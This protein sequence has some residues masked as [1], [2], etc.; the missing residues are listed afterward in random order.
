MRFSLRNLLICVTLLFLLLPAMR[1]IAEYI[2]REREKG[3]LFAEIERLKLK[4]EK[5]R[6][7]RIYNTNRPTSRIKLQEA[8]LRRLDEEIERLVG[9][10][11]EIHRLLEIVDKASHSPDP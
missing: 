3:I 10:D 8:E 1:P 7:A 2:R 4:L 11:G 5:E 9:S 6:A